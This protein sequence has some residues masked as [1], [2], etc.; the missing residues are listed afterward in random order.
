MIYLNNIDKCTIQR[1][2]FSLFVIIRSVLFIYLFFD[3]LWWPAW[4]SKSFVPYSFYS[5]GNFQFLF[6]NQFTLGNPTHLHNYKSY[7]NSNRVSLFRYPLRN[8]ARIFSSALI[9]IC[10]INIP[11]IFAVVTVIFR[12][13]LLQLFCCCCWWQCW[14]RCSQW[15]SIH[16]YLFSVLSS[17]KSLFERARTGV[18]KIRK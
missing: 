1:F 16:V 8:N 15:Q 18:R 7:V 3:L 9:F 14:R 5:P 11:I 2:H 4:V 13:S 12:F 10:I 17:D 6:F